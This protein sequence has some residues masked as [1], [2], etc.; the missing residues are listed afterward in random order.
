LDRSDFYGFVDGGSVL[1][2]VKD[3]N[4]KTPSH[5]WNNHIDEAYENTLKG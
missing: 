5:I 3:W 4:G 1:A 2:I